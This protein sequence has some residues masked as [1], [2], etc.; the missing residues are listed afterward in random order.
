MGIFFERRKNMARVKVYNNSFLATLVNLLGTGG[1]MVGALLLIDA[2][3]GPGIMMIVI[4]LVLMVL[5]SA[6]AEKANFRQWWKQIEKNG[7]LPEIKKSREVAVQVY[8]KNPG[9]ETLEK[10]RGLNP[11]AAAYI[12]NGFKEPAG[13]R[14]AAVQPRQPVQQ[15]QVQQVQQQSQQPV[16]QPPVVQQPAQQPVYRPPVYST[17]KTLDEQIDEICRTANDNLA[18]QN[19]AEIHWQCAQR[20]EGLLKSYPNHE[21]LIRN[22]AQNLANYSWYS[23]GKPF[24]ERRR[25]YSA[26]L[27]S[28]TLE[29]QKREVEEM[30][31]RKHCLV[32]HAVHGGIDAGNLHDI[33]AMEDARQWL[34]TAAAYRV[35]IPDAKR[36]QYENV[37]VPSTQFYVGYWLAKAYLDQNPPQKQKAKAVLEEALQACPYA[38][39][40]QCDINPN[41]HANTDTL[42]TREHL[43]GLLNQASS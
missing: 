26:S 24:D 32:T 5:A 42:M 28:L 15:R 43:L 20:L 14:Q 6:I 12:E 30:D 33:S 19:D 21:R 9:K 25:A 27:R 38:L 2:E 7:L 17:T 13:A 41:L 18:G 3:F 40:R 31:R 35:E 16:Y 29:T 37:A 10:I 11:A 22:V 1:L 8:Q 36:Q 34:R 23:T 39:I 4:G